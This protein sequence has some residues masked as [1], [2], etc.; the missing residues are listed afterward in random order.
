MSTTYVVTGVTRGIGWA[1]LENL[2]QNPENTV[3]ALV[4]NKAGTEKRVVEEL[5]SPKNVHVVEADLTNYASIEGRAKKVIALGSGLADTHLTAKY[6]LDLGSPYSMSK[7]AL[8]MLVAKYHASYA[9]QGVLFLSI[10]PGLVDTGHQSQLTE[11]GMLNL[12]RMLASFA[13]YAPGFKMFTPEESVGY[14]MK[15][16]AD[17]TVE[18]YGGTAVSHHGDDKWL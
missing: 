8:N 12:Q 16:V 10:S 1:F 17:A 5:G 4:R 13:E 15:V 18:K 9:D 7:A 2:S 11:E 14:M 3:I 6:R